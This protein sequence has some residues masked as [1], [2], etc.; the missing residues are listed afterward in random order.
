MI[1][2]LIYFLC[3]QQVLER[4][5]ISKSAW[6]AG[7]QKGIY[8]P[9]SKLGCKSVWLNTDIDQIINNVAKRGQGDE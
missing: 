5:C 1:K 9:P 4:L 2:P 6:Y 3:L 7:I 8:P